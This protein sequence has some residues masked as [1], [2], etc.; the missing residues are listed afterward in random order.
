M[1]KDGWK[2]LALV[3]G[4]LLVVQTVRGALAGGG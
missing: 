3:L 4:G 2:T 1:S